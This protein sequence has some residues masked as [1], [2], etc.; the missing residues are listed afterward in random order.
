M[1]RDG[2]MWSVGPRYALVALGLIG[3]FNA[4]AVVAAADKYTVKDIGLLA[5]GGS[6]EGMNNNGQLVGA[7]PAGP[8]RFRGPEARPSMPFSMPTA[9]WPT[10][11][12]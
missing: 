12:R 9:R 10:W 6:V 4:A 3:F 7:L 11:A 1:G 8:T 2:I 5:S